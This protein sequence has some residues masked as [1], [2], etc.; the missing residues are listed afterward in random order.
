MEE[1]KLNEKPEEHT[2]DE[3][4]DKEL[5][6]HISDNKLDLEDKLIVEAAA[7][8]SISAALSIINYS[9]AYYD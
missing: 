7:S 5:K 1:H 9:G 4:L 2:L 3:V 8:A 6:E